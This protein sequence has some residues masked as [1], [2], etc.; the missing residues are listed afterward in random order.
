MV[1]GLYLAG[2]RESIFVFFLSLCISQGSSLCH[3]CDLLPCHWQEMASNG[4]K[5]QKMA[6]N[7][8]NSAFDVVGSRFI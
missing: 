1:N 4:K 7:G 6:F 2:S 8:I 5:W 3:F